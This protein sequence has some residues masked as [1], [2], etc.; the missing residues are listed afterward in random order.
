MNSPTFVIRG[1]SINEQAAEIFW[2]MSSRATF[3]SWNA[4]N[5]SPDEFVDTIE[6]SRNGVIRIFDTSNIS[7]ATM[8]SWGDR[9]T[10]VCNAPDTV[11]VWTQQNLDEA[12][13]SI[14]DDVRV[15]FHQWKPLSTTKET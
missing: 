9:C 12:L 6:P 5:V 13:H 4:D 2:K 8:P 15:E 11:V 1:K 3:H 10:S 14:G 7:V